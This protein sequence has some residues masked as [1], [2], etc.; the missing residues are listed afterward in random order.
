MVWRF[1]PLCVSSSVARSSASFFSHEVEMIWSMEKLCILVK[2][3]RASADSNHL[4]RLLFGSARSHSERSASSS[5]SGSGLHL[6]ERV[7]PS[8]VR[9]SNDGCR[10]KR[11]T[12][13]SLSAGFCKQHSRLR[14]IRFKSGSGQ[15]KEGLG[16][17]EKLAKVASLSRG[18]SL[19]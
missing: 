12:C 1:S 16:H 9:A 4:S 17:C 19:H 13:E 10:C 5:V 6:L 14:P 18:A 11:R 8:V 2:S 15:K 7:Y 3:C